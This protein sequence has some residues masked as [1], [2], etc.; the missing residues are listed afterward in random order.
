MFLFPA[1]ASKMSEASRFWG[2]KKN[3]S[4]VNIHFPGLNFSEILCLQKYVSIQKV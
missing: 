4:E 1:E 3:T 2:L